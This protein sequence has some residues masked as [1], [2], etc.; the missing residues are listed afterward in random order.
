MGRRQPSHKLIEP[1]HGSA[2]PHL[3]RDVVGSPV[4]RG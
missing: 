2:A 3:R 1:R 4:R